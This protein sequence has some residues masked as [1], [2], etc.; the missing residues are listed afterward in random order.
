MTRAPD[1]TPPVES[2]T[3]PVRMRDDAACVPWEAAVGETVR[4]WPASA[5]TSTYGVAASSKQQVRVLSFMSLGII[6]KS[7]W[8]MATGD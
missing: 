5:F 4:V 3:V 2:R 6:P 1:T 8:L 7:T